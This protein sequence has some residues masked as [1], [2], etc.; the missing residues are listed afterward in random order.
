MKSKATLLAAALLP[1]ITFAQA[2]SYDPAT[3]QRFDAY[4]RPLPSIEEMCRQGQ[5][6]GG[7]ITAQCGIYD[8]RFNRK[9]ERLVRYHFDRWGYNILDNSVTESDARRLDT[10]PAFRTKYIKQHG[11]EKYKTGGNPAS[12]DEQSEQPVN[13]GFLDNGHTEVDV[14][15]SSVQRESWYHVTVNVL[16]KRAQDASLLNVKITCTG[17]DSSTFSY[18]RHKVTFDADGSAHF[19]PGVFAGTGASA[20]SRDTPF[21]LLTM[22]Y[23]PSEWERGH[24]GQGIP[25]PSDSDYQSKTHDQQRQ[26]TGRW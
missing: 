21:S 19:G 15:E 4:G 9:G 5:M 2:Y 16:V 8:Y 22:R 25:T 3:G 13:I 20:F 6:A 10:D 12:A 14:Y 23:C 24:V 18:S 7:P 17:R 1:S 26:L 11:Y